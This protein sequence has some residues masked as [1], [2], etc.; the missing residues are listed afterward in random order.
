MMLL[1]LV[2]VIIAFILNLNAPAVF[3]NM[4]AVSLAI[5]FVATI[6]VAYFMINK[7]IPNKMAISRFFNCFLLGFTI[8]LLILHFYWTPVELVS[9]G[10]DPARYYNYAATMIKGNVVI[11]GLNYWGVVFFYYALF[12]VFGLDPMVPLFLNV[13]LVLYVILLLSRFLNKAG[14][15]YKTSAW[16]LLI[17]EIIYYNDMSSREILCMVFGV[18]VIVNFYRVYN[19][20]VSI[21]RL[22]PTITILLLMIIIRPPYGIGAVIAI[23]LYFL[24][25]TKKRMKAIFYSAIMSVVVAVGLYA[26]G[27]IGDFNNDVGSSLSSTMEGR[28]SGDN[29]KGDDFVYSQNSMAAKLIPHNPI[30]FVVYG[31][32]RTMAYVIVTPADII[33]PIGSFNIFTDVN[34]YTEWTTLL[35][36]LLIP[37]VYKTIKNHFKKE[38]EVKILAIAF[39][40]FFL[41]V[42]VFNTTLIQQRYRLVY[43]LF[44]FSLAL[45][46]LSKRK[47]SKPVIVNAFHK[48]NNSSKIGG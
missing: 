19:R 3:S 6:G 37:R 21:V 1:L 10:F 9:A 46:Y 12:K 24:F 15:P 2:A 36:M 17:P 11:E 47:C 39:F 4:T 41:M 44:Y 31:L 7:M 14:V 22:I 48:N 35:M 34:G 8:S 18:Y 13:L 40:V 38:K 29:T 26:A 23:G 16:L 28:I 5:E 45:I 33:D 27:N 20:E 43:D 42:G 30:Q 32:I 25:V